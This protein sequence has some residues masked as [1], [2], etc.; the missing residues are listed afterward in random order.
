AMWSGPR[1][2][3][4]AMMRAWENRADTTV[5]D[6]PFYAAYLTIT[7]IEHPMNEAVIASQPEDWRV[8][9]DEISGPAS[10]GAAIW[11]QKHMA[12]HMVAEIGR[13]WF[14]NLRHAFLIRDPDQVVASYAEKRQTI[15]PLD[16]GY[17]LQ[18]ELFDEVIAR[19]GVTPPVI[20]ASDVLKQPRASLQ[21]LCAALDVAFEHE[22]LAWPAGPRE[23]DGAWAPHWYASVEAST[24][25]RPWQ[26]PKL[27]LDREQKA[28]AQACRPAYEH[29][30]RFRLAVP[31]DSEE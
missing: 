9:A 29:L 31:A 14:P 1:N 26:E 21:A 18:A 20:E 4:T 15:T 24:G 11:F 7:R 28:V 25:F 8:V 30:S 5:I 2:I 13:D 22:M 27:V 12:H 19:T 16:L 23:S 17:D 3:S 10:D 6:E